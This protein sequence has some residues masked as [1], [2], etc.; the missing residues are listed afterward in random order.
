MKENIE[1]VGIKIAGFWN[2]IEE[3][4]DIIDIRD[5][6][7]IFNNILYKDAIK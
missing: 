2:G 3:I 5:I 1:N 4:L 6:G 7:N